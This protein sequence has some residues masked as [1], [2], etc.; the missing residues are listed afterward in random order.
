MGL[1]ENQT[2]DVILE[3]ML[4]RVPVKYD[5][6]VGSIIFTSNAPTAEELQL[7]YEAFD[8]ILDQMLPD[9]AGRE[10]LIRHCASRKIIPKSASAVAV[11]GRFAPFDVA[12]N[13]GARFNCGQY[14]YKV[15]DSLPG[16]IKAPESDGAYC[17]RYLVCETIGDEPNGTISG[18]LIPG[19]T[20]EGLESAAIERLA[21]EGED[22][23]S[24]EALRQR[25]YDSFSAEAFGGNRA[26]YKQAILNMQGVGAVKIYSAHNGG[27]T[28]LV[29]VKGIS[30]SYAP[31]EDLVQVIQMATDP[32]VIDPGE[33][34]WGKGYGFAPV[35]HH[36]TVIGVNG[37]AIAVK[38]KLVIASGHD[39][40]D[41]EDNIQSMLQ[42][43]Y[44]ELNRMWASSN[45]I[46]VKGA[47][48]SSRLLDIALVEDVIG[49]PLLICGEKQG[50]N[51]TVDA[52]SIAVYGS[53]EN[54]A[55]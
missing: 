55:D 40:S 42:G 37:D 38:A 34:T 15:V 18:T 43:Y 23:E 51:I 26:D 1:Y 11:L 47:E 8:Y 32:R 48:I 2:A 29:V 44:A 30:D 52:N 35:G 13:V 49:S 10:F 17:Y 4:A 31:S 6:R 28:S 27:S 41:V 16:G 14:W 33:E 24:T 25:Y 3:R 39:Y 53:F 21:I 22:E 36:V 50:Q 5:R 9:T 46:V 19:E 7:V 12:I 45:G 54:I 20:I